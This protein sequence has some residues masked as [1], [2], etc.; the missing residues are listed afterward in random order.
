MTDP[1]TTVAVANGLMTALAANEAARLALES[2]IALVA[3][4]VVV[5]PAAAAPT[6][7]AG[8][9][10][11]EH[12]K[13]QQLTGFGSGPSQYRCDDCRAEWSEAD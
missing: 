7:T 1:D 12:P 10:A 4:G 11:C 3:D 5:E 13:P 9:G 2:A 6:A 8:D